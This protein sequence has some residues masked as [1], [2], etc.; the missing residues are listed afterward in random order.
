MKVACVHPGRTAWDVQGR[1]AGSIDVP[2]SD[3]GAHD[4]EKLSDPL[5]EL[6]PQ[7]V[8]AADMEPSRGS[9]RILAD[10]LGVRLRCRAELNELDMGVWQGLLIKDIAHKH[11]KAWRT[12]RHDPFRNTPPGAEDPWEVARRVR[13]L[14]EMLDRKHPGD[15]VILVAG[16]M[17]CRIAES[18][19]TRRDFEGR[20]SPSESPAG[21][22]VIVERAFT[23]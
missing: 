20:I 2:L 10:A 6:A 8:Y 23:V 3:Q 13:S 19:L 14:V 18:V 21:A 9:A 22:Y 15:N 4:I 11:P 5:R 17:V 16:P 7:A 1:L 12:W